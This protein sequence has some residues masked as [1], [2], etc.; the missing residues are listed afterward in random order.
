MALD[1]QIIPVDFSGGLD[2]KL[3]P[4]L[5]LPG[6]LETA[7]NYVFDDANTLKKRPALRAASTTS[8]GT[9]K[10]GWA[11]KNQLAIQTDADDVRVWD[12]NNN[13]WTNKGFASNHELSAQALIRN[14]SQQTQAS[15]IDNGS[16]SIAVWSDSRGGIRYSIFSNSGVAL[17]SD[18]SISTTGHHPRLVASINDSSIAFLI[19]L[20]GTAIKMAYCDDGSTGFLAPVTIA[21]DALNDPGAGLDACAHDAAGAEFWVAYRL[22]TNQIKVRI[23]NVS[24]TSLANAT[25]AFTAVGYISLTRSHLTGGNEEPLLLY[26]HA[27]GIRGAVYAVNGAFT[28]L[29]TRWQALLKGAAVGEGFPAFT[30]DTATGSLQQVVY[31]SY[32]ANNRVLRAFTVNDSGV[33]ASERDL[34]RGLS[35]ASMF[36]E[37]STACPRGVWG[38]YPSDLQPTYFFIGC[39]AADTTIDK[40]VYARALGTV[41]GA[42]ED[43]TRRALGP[44]QGYSVPL[45]GALRQRGRP[46]LNSDGTFLG[47]ITPVGVSRVELADRV[48]GSAVSQGGAL[49][50]SGACPMQFDGDRAVE[51]GFHVYPEGLLVVDDGVG[52]MAAGTYQ[53]C[54]TYE[55]LNAQGEL[56]RSAP[57][58]PVSVTIAVNRKIGVT[59]PTLRVTAKT[60]SPVSIVVWA[61]TAN[62][63]IFYRANELSAL[64]N[65]DPTLD[66]KTFSL[67]QNA[68]TLSANEVLYTVGGELDNEPPPPHRF[69][70]A[71]QGRLFL[72]GLE[73]P[74]EVAL[75]KQQ[76]TGSSQPPAFSSYLKL[77]VPEDFG[78]VRGGIS[79]GDKCLIACEHGWWYLAGT[80]PNAQGEQYGYTDPQPL[81]LGVGCVSHR[82]ITATQDGIAFVSRKG[83]RLISPGLA[84]GITEKGTPWG[85]DVDSL[86]T[87]KVLAGYY[88]EFSGFVSN[89]KDKL[90]IAVDGTAFVFDLVWRQWTT[91]ALPASGLVSAFSLRISSLMETPVPCFLTGTYLL[92]EQSYENF[93]QSQDFLLANSTITGTV[94]TGWMK[95][96]SV[97]G[98]QRVKKLLLLGDRLA[99]GNI[100]VSIGYDYEAAY[101]E[102]VSYNTGAVAVVQLEHRLSRQKCSA[103]RVKIVDDANGLGLRLTNLSF[104]AGVKKGV[105]KLSATKRF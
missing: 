53:V 60:A 80:G 45:V 24:G 48:N 41:A 83:I 23:C 61:T 38:L 35:L 33:V 2:K 68:A 50:I 77:R 21:N 64:I 49:R 18:V 26:E 47:E 100:T 51:D 93:G 98:Y 34:I 94:E 5:T 85:A 44:M 6:K 59:I 86:V 74:F 57:S 10:N 87:A 58:I 8:M 40:K 52:I 19:F 101:S 81:N 28:A 88:E 66:V 55:W 72:G 22:A 99:G 75:S 73:D 4:K 90:V 103:I 30:A 92:T 37:G 11:W 62:Q 25:E 9:P 15:L 96:A 84:L 36:S 27:T 63:T 102:T 17:L 56:E 78:D 39:A 3:D 43:D 91:A 69:S 29:S 70:W 54:A 105:N 42:I 82:S 1:E 76:V 20:E 14:N 16:H 79:Y 95:F 46:V 32:L 104:L 65:N 12:P 31:E 71:H 97:S 7:Q 89:D 13:T 67:N